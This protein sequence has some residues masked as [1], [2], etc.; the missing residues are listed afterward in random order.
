MELLLAHLPNIA[1]PNETVQS[2][3]FTESICSLGLFCTPCLPK[4]DD[5]EGGIIHL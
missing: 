1:P 4:H 5:S 3:I 2:K